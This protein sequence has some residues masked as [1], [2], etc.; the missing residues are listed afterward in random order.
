VKLATLKL[1]KLF[2]LFS[3]L[4]TTSCNDLTLKSI[5]EGEIVYKL[6]YPNSED[7]LLV[8]VM[9]DKMYFKFK[10]G[11]TISEFPAGMGLFNMAIKTD[12]KTKTLRQEVQ[13]LTQKKCIT[14]TYDNLQ[15]LLAQDPPIKIETSNET[16]EICGYKC[17]KA[18]V[19]FP[20][21]ERESF[22]IFYTNKIKLP[23]ANWYNQFSSIDGVILE[24]NLKRWG[25]ETKFQAIK[26]I[27]KEID[28]EI[29][30]PDPEYIPVSQEEIDQIFENFN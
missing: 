15:K 14:Y 17:K 5:K 9:P 21:K 11:K 30:N 12:Y 16:K 4:F 13:V 26:V 10:D 27:P 8:D 23:N 19:S 28:D 29:F 20:G 2:I 6:T 25:F 22:E 24:Y 18:Y 7:N 1:I 3:L